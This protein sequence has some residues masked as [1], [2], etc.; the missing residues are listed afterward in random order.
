MF[1]FFNL[2]SLLDSDYL[3]SIVENTF[4]L[5]FT[6]LISGR[7]GAVAIPSFI[8]NMLTNFLKD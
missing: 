8:W 4:F 5:P 3:L 2:G 7:A 6:S 1:Q